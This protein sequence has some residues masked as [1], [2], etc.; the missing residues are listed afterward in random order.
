MDNKI[1]KRFVNE[2]QT[3]EERRAKYKIAQE[4]GMKPK[5]AR[6]YR[7]RE[8]PKMYRRLGLKAPRGQEKAAL[9][10]NHG[11]IKDVDAIKREAEPQ[12]P[13][14]ELQD[15][16][17]GDIKYME[18][19]SLMNHINEILTKQQKVYL[20][21]TQMP[22]SNVQVM[23][24]EK[25][26]RYYLA[27][28]RGEG[29]GN[30]NEA[31]EQVNNMQDNE[32]NNPQVNPMA[33]QDD[34]EVED[35]EEE[36]IIEPI[37]ETPDIKLQHEGYAEIDKTR[38]LRTISNLLGK[39][40][41]K[42]NNKDKSFLDRESGGNAITTLNKKELLNN[43]DKLQKSE[44]NAVIIDNFLEGY[45]ELALIGSD[46]PIEKIE[47][48]NIL[49]N[50]VNK[51]YNFNDS[52]INKSYDR[53]SLVI[54]IDSVAHQLHQVHKA[55]QK[56]NENLLNKGISGHLGTETIRPVFPVLDKLAEISKALGEDDRDDR[57]ILISKSTDNINL[58]PMNHL[59]VFHKSLS[60]DNG[61]SYWN[62]AKKAIKSGVK[63]LDDDELIT[64]REWI[65]SRI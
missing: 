14:T 13:K 26:G 50:K 17:I 15:K 44:N 36:P 61:P 62:L 56:H 52:K 51:I 27:G 40:E 20:N 35:K 65:Y 28:G 60:F 6:V 47:A 58:K 49:A 59:E 37:K 41:N 2:F 39:P 25:G 24:G 46:Y 4:L 12:K 55:N 34:A 16:I 21:E 18:R 8:F 53:L 57:L 32:M 7:D 1:N 64:L 33:P 22:P 63:S 43:I 29:E 54:N 30:E 9:M 48:L 23:Q 19:K 45:K 31:Q 10:R 38:L 5:E 11:V 3:P 42:D